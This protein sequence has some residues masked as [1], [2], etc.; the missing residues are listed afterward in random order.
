MKAQNLAGSV[1]AIIILAVAI[2][3]AGC[4]S[5]PEEAPP[6]EPEPTQQAEPEA[7]PEPEPGVEAPEALYQ[8]AQE[9]RGQIQEFSLASYNEEQW[10]AGESSFES[11]ESAYEAQEYGDARESLVAAVEAYNEV[12]ASAVSVIIPER[13]SSAQTARDQAQAARANV[14][15]QEEFEAAVATFDEALQAVE[16][17][18]YQRAVALFQEAEDAF[19]RLTSEALAKRAEA[20]AA[21]EEIRQ[22][23]DSLE[24][25]R[26]GLESETRRE[27]DEDEE[28]QQ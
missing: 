27:F 2:V 17:E 25:Q 18:E 7:E 10:E 19:E 14:A 21:L 28:A 8:E 11:G 13:R 3:L 24:E 12:I 15:L 9:L 1:P 20:E 5:A 16:N 6:Q 23:L 22:N 4:A 26:E